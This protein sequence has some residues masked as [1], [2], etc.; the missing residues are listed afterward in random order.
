MPDHPVN[1]SVQLLD[2]NFYANDPHE[3]FTWMRKNA[4]VYFDPDGHVWGITLHED[5]MNCSKNS[6][7]YCNR[8]GMRPDSPAIPSMSCCTSSWRRLL[9][10]R[11]T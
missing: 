11:M 9:R 7:L 3:A 5:V 8:F 4:P 10:E 1:S 6:D 2:G